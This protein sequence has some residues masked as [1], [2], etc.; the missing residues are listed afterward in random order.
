MLNA[1][2]C[3][4]YNSIA[5]LSGL[6]IGRLRYCVRASRGFPNRKH[7]GLIAERLSAWRRIS[8]IVCM[9]VCIASNPG[10]LPPPRAHAPYVLIMRRWF[11]GGRRPGRF[12]HVM[13]ATTYICHRS[14]VVP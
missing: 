4:M 9:Y 12:Y 7:L 1:V 8:E 10:L 2:L 13:R 6:V 11:F 5:A 3:V 14:S